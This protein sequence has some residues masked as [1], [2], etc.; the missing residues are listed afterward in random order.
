MKRISLQ[1][2]ACGN[3][4]FRNELRMYS[5]SAKRDNTM[6]VFCKKC[7]WNVKFVLGVSR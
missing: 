4:T 2:K 3:G 6:V 5:P 7:S 1:C